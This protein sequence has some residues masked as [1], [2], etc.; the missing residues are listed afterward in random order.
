MRSHYQQRRREEEERLERFRMERL[1]QGARR[2]IATEDAPAAPPEP[3]APDIPMETETTTETRQEAG[4]DGSGAKQSVK[5]ERSAPARGYGGAGDATPGDP[6][7]MRAGRSTEPQ[8]AV[9][10]GRLAGG[11]VED[12][13]KAPVRGVLDALES[14]EGFVYAGAKDL[15]GLTEREGV[16]LDNP[17]ARVEGVFSQAKRAVAFS[18]PDA[19]GPKLVAGLTQIMVPYIGIAG[20]LKA[21]GMAGSLGKDAARALTADALT[22]AVAIDPHGDRL[23][24]MLNAVPGLDPWIPD[25]LASN[26]EDAP[27]YEG[28][29]KNM[30]EV[31]IVGGGLELFMGGLRLMRAARKAG[32]VEPPTPQS[33]A[34]GRVAREAALDEAAGGRAQADA[35]IARALAE[36]D[37]GQAARTSEDMEAEAAARATERMQD[38]HGMIPGED[39]ALYTKLLEEERAGM[40]APDRGA[41]EGA[42]AVERATERMREEHGM[43]PGEDEA[44][45]SRLLAEEGAP[46]TEKA[47]AKAVEANDAPL[48]YEQVEAMRLA[49]LKKTQDRAAAVEQA[50]EDAPPAPARGSRE[51]KEARGAPAMAEL[52]KGGWTPSTPASAARAARQ[53]LQGT[54]ADIERFRAASPRFADA[55]PDADAMLDATEA[56]V[57]YATRVAG[58]IVRK[59]DEALSRRSPALTPAQASLDR[60]RQAAQ[61]QRQAE[62]LSDPTSHAAV[63]LRQ[64]KS[65]LRHLDTL[66]RTASPSAWEFTGGK[67]R[68]TKA[69]AARQL[70]LARAAALRAANARL[71]RTMDTQMDA[72]RLSRAEEAQE[73]LDTPAP[74]E[75]AE[76]SV[77]GP[78]QGAVGDAAARHRDVVRALWRARPVDA[79]M[80]VGVDTHA[81]ARADR[82]VAYAVLDAE[83]VLPGMTRGEEQAEIAAWERDALSIAPL[84]VRE[85][86]ARGIADRMET[87]ERSGLMV[88][89]DWGQSVEDFAS[90]PAR[91]REARG[92]LADAGRDAEALK[93]LEALRFDLGPDFTAVREGLDG[94]AEHLDLF[95]AMA[96]DLKRAAGRAV[97]GTKDL[98]ATHE[99]RL[100]ME[101]FG[102][103]ARWLYGQ[104]D[105]AREVLDYSQGR[106]EYFAMDPEARWSAGMREGEKAG[107][108]VMPP[109]ASFRVATDFEALAR[110]AVDHT[111]KPIR[112]DGMYRITQAMIHMRASGLLSGLTTHAKNVVGNFANLAVKLPVSYVSA[113]HREGFEAA[114]GEVAALWEGFQEGIRGTLRI[115]NQSRI[116]QGFAKADTRARLE[117]SIEGTLDEA[118]LNQFIRTEKFDI[119]AGQQEHQRHFGQMALS[120]GRAGI[121][122][123][124]VHAAEDLH[125]GFGQAVRTASGLI[126]SAIDAPLAALQAED[127][128]FKLVAYKGEIKRQAFIQVQREMRAADFDPGTEWA[129]DWKDGRWGS[130]AA[131]RQFISDEVAHITENAYRAEPG[132][133]D[134]GL[135][136]AAIRYAEEATFTQRLDATNQKVLD[137]LN[138][139]AWGAGRIAMPFYTVLMNIGRTSLAYTPGMRKLWSTFSDTTRRELAQMDALQKSDHFA[140][141]FVGAAAFGAA[142]SLY[143]NGTLTGGAPTKGQFKRAHGQ[144]RQPYSIRVGDTWIGDY[145]ELLPGVGALVAIGAD[146]TE[147]AAAAVT[148]DEMSFAEAGV[149]LSLQIAAN[150][151]DQTALTTIA[152]TMEDVGKVVAAHESGNLSE[153]GARMAVRELGQISASLL[154]YSAFTRRLADA[155]DGGT[156]RR[157]Q[158]AGVDVEGNELAF[159][160]QVWG[161]FR[162]EAA[163]R[164]LWLS[165]E[166]PPVRGWDGE[167]LLRSVPGS[168]T[169]M[170]A[171]VAAFLS[172]LSMMK[173]DT[174]D[175][176]VRAMLDN[177]VAPDWTDR[178]FHFSAA[179]LDVSTPLLPEEYDWLARR[180]GVLNRQAVDR[181][182]GSAWFKGLRPGIDQQNALRAVFGAV[183]RQAEAEL[184]ARFPN[185]DVRLHKEMMRE[186]DRLQASAR[187]QQEAA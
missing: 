173:A 26:D 180:R 153:Q 18:D 90:A 27:Y 126:S 135:H 125:A 171:G 28:V 29:I 9:D 1:V 161:Q 79:A 53:A 97:I 107:A 145:R 154:P 111:D 39:E 174:R 149:A 182:T 38:E 178:T 151:L 110:A 148:P 94:A 146:A 187:R 13:A 141:Q 95:Y 98:S 25:Y 8:E 156:K 184:Q 44:L 34:E 61:R 20:R 158:A 101:R 102:A 177:E 65:V 118:L 157:L 108:Q 62:A 74:R 152:E 66:A 86:H 105:K 52:E 140:R 24:T 144:L 32:E 122:V 120:G 37:E 33:A 63:E 35:G 57:D 51:D 159:Y 41:P 15:W 136:E 75:T 76:A 2:D 134:A 150:L 88:R 87:V 14:V 183:E 143:Y 73:T 71:Q 5:T 6:Q 60:G 169:G 70:V 31:G 170:A 121:L 43:I 36:G 100:A 72:R 99:V 186:M 10:E 162:N 42:D 89:D 85:E 127:M 96:N 83:G 12:Y 54:R 164:F 160:Q 138:E 84:P 133:V 103:Y 11:T 16:R 163:R 80:E 48:T 112:T 92:T 68:F 3:E 119:H 179:G 40:D 55:E 155:V 4:L 47:A 64:A 46:R 124:A 49:S 58:G 106:V 113:V 167:V 131:R 172:P 82:Q 114:N 78:S 185:L 132:G 7:A 77:Q 30:V 116:R 21:A 50:A 130:Q 91:V 137:T 129:K 142:A 123:E 166:L 181:L 147:L 23:A 117:R 45:F 109:A 104:D 67:T 19:V 93:S 128:V 175:P 22:S 176:G 69:R 165:D 168:Q 17:D 139:K 56:A 115:A 59:Y 81:M